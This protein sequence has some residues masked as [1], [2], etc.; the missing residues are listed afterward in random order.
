MVLA[1]NRGERILMWL[2]GSNLMCFRIS[3]LA[4]E[5]W[6]FFF[7]LN[8]KGQWPSRGGGLRSPVISGRVDRI[9]DMLRRRKE[10]QGKQGSLQT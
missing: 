10:G 6:I 2:S 1:L 4:L 7:F 9:K 8:K 5:S 3:C